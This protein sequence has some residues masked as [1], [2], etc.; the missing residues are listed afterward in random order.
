MRR[1][2]LF[3]FLISLMPS[4]QFKINFRIAA[5]NN[6]RVAVSNLRV[7]TQPTLFSYIIVIIL[8]IINFI[9]TIISAVICFMF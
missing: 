8:I 7:F 6:T 5:V 1:C 9:I 3:W 2:N 4:I